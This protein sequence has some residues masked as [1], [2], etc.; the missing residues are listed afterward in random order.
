MNTGAEMGELSLLEL[1]ERFQTGFRIFVKQLFSSLK[2]KQL[3]GT[4][5][6]GEMLAQQAK[7]YCE[8]KIPVV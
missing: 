6:T 5:L 4:Y 1:D 7:S 2:P 3:F 8:A